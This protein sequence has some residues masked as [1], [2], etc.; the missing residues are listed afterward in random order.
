ME[1]ERHGEHAY[2]YGLDEGEDSKTGGPEL[3]LR[4]ELEEQHQAR[5]IGMRNSAVQREDRA[6]TAKSNKFKT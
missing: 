4:R 6:S 1:P 5:L 2:S 3:E